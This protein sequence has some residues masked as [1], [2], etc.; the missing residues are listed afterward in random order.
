MATLTTLFSFDGADD[1]SNPKAGLSIDATG[2]LL[3]ATATGGAYG[4]GT[5][6]E[7]PYSG[8]IYGGTPTTLVSFG[9]T[10]GSSP[11]GGLIF[12]AAGDLFGTT[13]T[14]GTSAGGAF[15]YGTVFEIPHSGGSYAS[16]PTTLVSFNGANGS[17]PL[18]G[19]VAD[20]TGDL[21]GTTSLGGVPGN[22]G[23]V[24]EIP[25]VGGS[26]ASTPTT[27]FS[28]D[29]G[30]DGSLS[31]GGAAQ[32]N[33]P[34]DEAR[35]DEGLILDAAGNLLGTTYQGGPNQ[36]GGFGTVFEISKTASGYANGGGL[37]MSVPFNA[38]NGAYPFA[39][40]VADAA[41]DLFGTT[42]GIETTPV[43]GGA[44]FGTVF[45]IPK[46]GS[47]YG[48]LITLVTFSDTGG[49]AAYP[50][51]S[52]I[53]DAAGDLFGTTYGGG[54][55]GNGTVFEVAKT[56][57]GYVSLPS[58]L[59]SFAGNTGGGP[60]GLIANAA[61]D[62]FG[63]TDQGGANNDGSVF[64]ITGSGFKVSPPAL[65][66]TG[67]FAGQ[68]VTDEATIAP[69]SNVA[70]ADANSGQ[71]E[72]VTVTLSAAAN[73]SLIDP[74][75]GSYN[76]A[77]GVYMVSGTAASVSTAL[78]G[79][80][81]NPT[82]FQAA[83]GL[84]VA[85][86]FTINVTD[87]AGQSATD[88]TTSVITTETQDPHYNGVASA[89]QA[90]LRSS[91]TPVSADQVAL[92][93][94]AGQTSL[95]QYETGLITSEQAI[96]ST[97]PALVTI[98]AFYGATPSSALLTT[99][100]TA[101]GGTSYYTA[102][103]LHNLGY[104]DPNVWTV[105]A[106]GWGA[107]P[108]STFYSQ[109]DSDATATTAGY[110]AFINAV[111]QTEFGA[112]PAAPNLQNLLGDIPGLAALLSGGGNVATPIEV[113]GGLYGYLLYVGQTNGIGHYASA[114]DAFLQAAANGIVTYGPELTAEFPSATGTAANSA[115]E[116]AAG[117]TASNVANPSVITVTTS[118]QLIDPGAGNFII[119]FQVGASGDTLMLRIGGV[120]QVSG[121]DP[122]TDV[123]DLRCLLT[124]TGLDLTGNMAALGHY[125]MVVDQG[126][127]A[128]LNC[129]PSG[130][131]GGGGTVAVLKGL[132]ATVTGL[133]TLLA[134][135]A[136]RMT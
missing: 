135:G 36:P 79:L 55:F 20:G 64:E 120:D 72:T 136:I 11:N 127:N 118:D 34:E 110:T 82:L 103:E 7:I 59:V 48:A 42:Y 65:T 3:G 21:F 115:A 30:T 133:D 86:T 96:Y 116:E 44:N 66:I 25:D 63:T 56:A 16:V 129:D 85:T 41:G 23:T 17:D 60:S 61:G 101:V 119:Q 75:G 112:R 105:I 104:S 1:G 117:A 78:D 76:T 33:S 40:L 47:G 73:G 28:F 2:D 93:I 46:T 97:L 108:T 113:M 111:Y 107:D 6:F 13:A 92:Q 18:A 74:E 134:Q 15:G 71:T 70:I 106:S 14:G 95:A 124:G 122:A 35:P 39:G 26:Y 126:S 84:T 98:D 37:S 38:V 132:G 4:W 114:A 58:T 100:A 91:P 87:T 5:V 123:L 31:T 45:E 88:S 128:L 57:T 12:D 130:Q 43:D 69:F 102:T 32:G 24:F 9:G 109:Y 8:G 83:A 94:T 90:I 81:F 121:F 29:G 89:Y 62:L 19:L 77:T 125:L 50:D 51:S 22:H 52:L 49:G 80:V 68:A 10:N 27:L 131:G 54:T 67:T 53:V 99:V